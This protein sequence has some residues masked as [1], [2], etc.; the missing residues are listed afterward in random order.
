MK[1]QQQWPFHEDKKDQ[2]DWLLVS[3]FCF[4]DAPFNLNRM[5]MIPV[6]LLCWGWF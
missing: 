1:I 4:V 3:E 2:Y 5:M 6:A